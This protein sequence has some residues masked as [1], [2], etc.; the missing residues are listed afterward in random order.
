MEPHVPHP[1]YRL[2][3]HLESRGY[4]TSFHFGFD[5]EIGVIAI[6]PSRLR[7]FYFVTLKNYNHYFRPPPPRLVYVSCDEDWGDTLVHVS[8]KEEPFK[9]FDLKEPDAFEQVRSEIDRRRL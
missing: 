1:F 8:S 2:N 5:G 9:V 3:K 7:R 4:I 6:Y